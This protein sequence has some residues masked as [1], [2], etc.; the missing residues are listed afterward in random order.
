VSLPSWIG[1]VIASSKQADV[2]LERLDTVLDGAPPNALVQHAPVYFRGALPDV[3]V[4][5][6]MAADYLDMLRVEGLTYRH[7]SSE[8][9][10]E[11]IDLRIER[12]AFVVI[13]GRVG[14]GKT[15]LLRVLLGLLP[16]D[17]GS[18]WWN[19][20]LVADPA[21]WFVPPR[22]AYTPQVPHLW[23]DTLRDNILAG[24]PQ[25]S[26]DLEAA[27]H[28]AVLERDLAEMNDGL[29]T[30]V[31]P[32]GV[33]LSGG[34]VQ[35]TAAARMFVRNPALLVFDDLSSALDV[36]TETQLWERLNER[37][38]HPDGTRGGRRN[39]LDVHTS[40]SSILHPSSLLVVSHRRAALRRADHVIVLR[41]GRIDAQGTL[42]YLLATSDEMRRLWAGAAEGDEDA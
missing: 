20:A 8:H 27:L 40:S 9:G 38:K 26:V 34:Q 6:R 16:R 41:D 22:A 28:A 2:S 37:M 3:R 25:Q 35:R 1:R 21:Q 18:I 23:S 7:P 19:D 32:R 39:Q 31:G 13:T 5:Q 29:D 24:L 36:D 15:T 30:V 17:G 14:S 10:I 11:N 4:P 12:G 42:H 33:R